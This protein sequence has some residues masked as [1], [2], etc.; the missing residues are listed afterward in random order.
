M[1][2]KNVINVVSKISIKEADT[3]QNVA[4]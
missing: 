1:G 3:F 2:I 4:Q